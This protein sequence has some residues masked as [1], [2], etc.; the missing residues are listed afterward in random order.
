MDPDNAEV[1]DVERVEIAPAGEG[2]E[3]VDDDTEDT[4]SD[5][6]QTETEGEDESTDEDAAKPDEIVKRQTPPAAASAAK[7]EAEGTDGLAEVPGETP[8]ERALR[9][10]VTR[11]KSLNRQER[12]AEILPHNTPPASKRE[13][14]DD[15]KNILGKYKPEEINALKEVLP[16]LAKEMG[17]VRQDEIAGNT[18]AE[19]SQEVLDSFLEKHPEYLPENDK[20]GTLWG[21][22]K[23]E[24][25]L[26]KQ[27]SN[28]KDFQKIFERVHRDVFGIKPAAGLTKVNAAREKASVASHAGASSQPSVAARRGTVA[29]QGLRLDMLKGFSPEEL[30]D[31]EGGE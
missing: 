15:E 25:G 22:F 14:T 5:S 13:L 8:R 12:V 6:S 29:P 16:A 27:P 20:D 23:T 1:K 18:Y 7:P 17:F 10:E 30:A 19:K 2:E 21:A 28:P 3:N 9:L 26:Y 4:E 31:L 11:L 24:Y